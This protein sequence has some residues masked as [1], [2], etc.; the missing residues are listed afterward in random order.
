VSTTDFN[1]DTLSWNFTA[2]TEN[3]YSG[4]YSGKIDTYMEHTGHGGWFNIYVEQELYMPASDVY[5]IAMAWK[6]DSENT[7]PGDH[8]RLEFILDGWSQPDDPDKPVTGWRYHKSTI[9]S[10][11]AGVHKYGIFMTCG[12]WNAGSRFHI[13][14]DDIKLVALA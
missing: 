1:Y 14:F 11:E 8:C 12:S 7:N 13:E 3:P 9:G 2:T 6:W 4:E 5:E 10:F